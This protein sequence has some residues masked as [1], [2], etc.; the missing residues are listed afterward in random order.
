MSE[1]QEPGSRLACGQGL[2]DHD[3]GAEASAYGAVGRLCHAG[4]CTGLLGTA[5]DFPHNQQPKRGEQEPRIEASGIS[6][7]VLNT[8]AACCSRRGGKTQG[9]AW[10]VGWFWEAGHHMPCAPVC[11]AFIR[12]PPF[13]KFQ[14]G[15]VVL[16]H[17]EL[18][19]PGVMHCNR[20]S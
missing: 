15:F 17:W 9:R 7:L 14:V 13:A 18:P 19:P 20:S 3:N 1:G 16:S 6:G 5:A 11:A 10:A 4:Y 2:P 12:P 8:Y